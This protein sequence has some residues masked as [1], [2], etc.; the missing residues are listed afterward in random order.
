MSL[1]R[2]QG[3]PSWTAP[4]EQA[5]SKHPSFMVGRRSI[6]LNQEI[7]LE[8]RIRIAP[9]GNADRVNSND[10]AIFPV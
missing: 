8:W 5:S 4:P 7:T 3:H 1:I 2:E 9:D 6:Q 10:T